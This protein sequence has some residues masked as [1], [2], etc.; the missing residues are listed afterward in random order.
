M[1]FSCFTWQFL[2]VNHFPSGMQFPD[3]LLKAKFK[4]LPNT[5]A[6]VFN[7]CNYSAIVYIFHIGVHIYTFKHFSVHFYEL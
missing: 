2:N 4:L 1:M 7:D 6:I 3:I 5:L